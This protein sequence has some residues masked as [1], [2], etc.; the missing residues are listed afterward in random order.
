MSEEAFE[1]LTDSGGS[2][3]AGDSSSPDPSTGELF[4]TMDIESPETLPTEEPIQEEA[5]KEDT[6]QE[7]KEAK[8]TE[9]QE[10]PK[11]TPEE[12]EEK[13]EETDKLEPFHKHPRFQ[14][15]NKTIKELKAQVE[16]LTAK[17]AEETPEDLGYR[18]IT[19]LTPDEIQD[20]QDEDPVGWA[21][22]LLMQAKAEARNDIHAE[23]HQNTMRAAADK[24]LDDFVKAH[25]DFDEVYESRVLSQYCDEH[26]GHN[27]ISA[28]LAINEEKAREAHGKEI[29]TLKASFEAEK[30]AAIDAA[31]KE[32][33]EKIQKQHRAK[34]SVTVITGDTTSPTVDDEDTDTGGDLTK[35]L[36]RQMIKETTA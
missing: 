19:K 11:E 9:T 6:L 2:P 23:A 26:P 24:T 17:P 35:F 4:E 12:P 18:D 22:N 16:Q 27:I 1:T 28:Y 32:A 21:K 36:H 31:V 3:E 20:W 33:V 30:K 29:E 15:M 8:E 5:A 7:E 34:E 13:T 10:K 14:E 25:P